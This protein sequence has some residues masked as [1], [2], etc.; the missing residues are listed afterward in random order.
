MSSLTLL[1]VL[2]IT[3]SFLCTYPSGCHCRVHLIVPKALATVGAFLFPSTLHLHRVPS[4]DAAA[5]TAFEVGRSYPKL[6]LLSHPTF[7]QWLHVI[8]WSLRIKLWRLYMMLQCLHLILSLCYV[9]MRPSGVTKI[10]CNPLT[11]SAGV[12]GV[13]SFGDNGYNLRCISSY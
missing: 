10:Q 9:Q 1:A 13:T 11:V 6:H 5:G 8:L 2:S 3:E 12:R 7:M 4:P